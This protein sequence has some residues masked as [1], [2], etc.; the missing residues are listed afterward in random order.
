MTRRRTVPRASTSTALVEARAPND[1][2]D[3]R[4]VPL[5]PP[6]PS[7]S[8]T[9]AVTPADRQTEVLEQ[10]CCVARGGELAVDPE[11]DDLTARRRR[12]RYDSG[13]RGAETARRHRLLGGDDASRLRSRSND[14]IHDRTGRSTLASRTR[15][16]IPLGDE[17]GGGSRAPATPS[18][19]IANHGGIGADPSGD[20]SARARMRPSGLLTSGPG[21][22]RRG[23]RSGVG[24][25][26]RLNGR[27]AGCRRSAGTTMSRPQRA[28]SQERSSMEWWVGPSSP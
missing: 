24:A 1:P 4:S 21:S 19:P 14:R 17:R 15:V 3:Q 26:T 5:R 6:R 13:D 18:S 12:A 23:C 27:R 16:S 2:H 22:G 7:T 20:P 10:E 25:A 28:R 9:A 8:R 11:F